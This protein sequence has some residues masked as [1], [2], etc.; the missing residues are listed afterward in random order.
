MSNDKLV[1]HSWAGL[2]NRLRVLFSYHYLNK[3]KKIIM[4]WE[5]NRACPGFFLDCFQPIENVEFSNKILDNI[6]IKT[7]SECSKTKKHFIYDNLKLRNEL[8]QKINKNLSI[9]NKFI[10]IQ[11]R[12]TD[13]I[14]SPWKKKKYLSDEEY[15]EFLN[16]YPNHN[17]YIATDN[18]ETQN[19]FY[20]LFKDRMKIIKLME[21][22]KKYIPGKRQTSIE[23]VII[24][25]YMCVN[26]EFFLGSSY[27][28]VTTLI[29]ELKKK[30][31]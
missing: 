9:M 14:S 4:I 5:N 12:R 23:D 6:D 27:S 25:I 13:T 24:D 7:N 8:K 30:K 2:C 1:I 21:K 26:A 31:N 19:K 18:F 28:S 17:I 22:P 16:K 20:S 15:I 11:I 10:A 3:K 29:K